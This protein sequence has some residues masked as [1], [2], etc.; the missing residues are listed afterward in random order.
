MHEALP[1]RKPHCTES[2][3]VIWTRKNRNNKKKHGVTFEI[4]VRVYLDDKRIEN[5]DTEH[6]TIDIETAGQE[7]FQPEKPSQMRRQNTMTLDE[8]KKLPP[9]TTEEIAEVM[10]FKNTDFEDCPKQTADELAKFRPW[11]EVHKDWYKSSGKRMPPRSAHCR[12]GNS[13]A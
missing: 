9:L 13:N 7:L 5:L 12:N 1:W 10:S 2:S 4:A 11:Y 3:R 8:V 6:P